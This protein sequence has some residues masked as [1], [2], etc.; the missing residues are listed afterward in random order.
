MSWLLSHF[1]Q[2]TGVSE[3][4]AVYL[5]PGSVCRVGRGDC[6]LVIADASVSRHH[7]DIEIVNNKVRLTDKSKFCKTRL[8]G[9]CL[10][11][12]HRS[13]EL[14][15]SDIICF[16]QTTTKFKLVWR[17]LVLLADFDL[18][19]PAGLV[20]STI[21]RSDAV[22]CVCRETFG[23]L[24]AAS[25]VLGLPLISENYL[26]A[27]ASLKSGVK[28]LPDLN[29]F[30][31]PGSRQPRR[32][33]LLEGVEVWFK[34]GSDHRDFEKAV[35]LA[36]GTAPE[37]QESQPVCL[38]I[39]G[40]SRKEIT[41][42]PCYSMT[43]DVFVTSLMGEPDGPSFLKCADLIDCPAVEIR[44]AVPNIA[45]VTGGEWISR[46]AGKMA[47]D[48]DVI[49]F[50]PQEQPQQ[51]KRVQ[52]KICRVV[53][54]VPLKKWSSGTNNIRF[55]QGMIDAESTGDLGMFDFQPA[56]QQRLV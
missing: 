11:A 19:Q 13:V 25:S 45:A 39:V 28:A 36:G 52:D 7:A 34:A 21:F 26:E 29:D 27:F 33:S 6:E 9:K 23:G 12:T 46:I 37:V 2:V 15:A 50:Q 51:V 42:F 10:S 56:K 14:K 38:V 22:A 40:F 18:S 47:G 44:E 20:L 24:A 8:N 1:Y 41:R 35:R 54:D 53:M 5:I 43:R 4:A 30:K 31:I 55:E 16:G 49:R 3:D 32:P 17:P 48:C